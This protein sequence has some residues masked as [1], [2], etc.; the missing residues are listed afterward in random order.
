MDY[1]VLVD[2][3]Q[4]P[5]KQTFDKTKCFDY[6]YYVIGGNHSVEAK[7]QLIEEYPNNYFFQ[8]VK[9]IIYVGLIYIESKLLARDHNADNEY[10]MK[11]TF[12]QTV[13]FIHNKFIENC[14][15]DKT[16]VS[17]AFRKECLMETCYQIED[18]INSKGAKVHSNIFKGMDNIFQLA[19]RTREIW[20]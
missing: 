10:R 15:G 17:V 6:K 9:C 4:V 2:P 7:R 5:N 8:T 16:Q 20:E 14:G 18:K 3:C 11:I 12:I 13:R 1:V 19:F